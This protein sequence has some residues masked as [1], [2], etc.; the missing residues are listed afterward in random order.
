MPPTPYR[1]GVLLLGLA[2]WAQLV[3]LPAWG[4]PGGPMA[5]GA[6]EWALGAL[7]LTILVGGSFAAGARGA[8]L[9]PIALL[10]AF[11]IALGAFGVGAEHSTQARFDMAARAVAAG[12]AVG[13]VVV[14]LAW[15]ATTVPG[16]PATLPPLERSPSRPAP[17]AL[18]R[19]APLALAAVAAFLAIV[20][21]GILSARAHLSRAERL[22]GEPLQRARE[23]LVSAAALGIALL[24]VLAGGASIVRGR[25]SERRGGTRALAYVVWAGA[26][27]G[28]YWLQGRLR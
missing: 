18:H 6:F 20:V 5:A 12:T 19:I 25:A 11:P 24:L 1:V 9:R 17:P 10:A 15:L 28:L 26:A 3:A 8:T 13:Y 23:A 22:G 16:L 7:A 27:G 21:P 2:L 4:A 14:C